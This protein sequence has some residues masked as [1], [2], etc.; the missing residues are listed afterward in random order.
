[1]ADPLNAALI[2]FFEPVMLSGTDYYPF[3]M[4]MRVGG[5]S[6]YKYGF[7]GKE[8]DNEVK[9]G[10]GTQQDYGMR[11]YD[12]RLGRFLSV[13]PLTQSFPFYTPYQFAGNTPIQAID[14]DGLEDI[15]YI[16]VWV[17]N[18]TG[19]EAVL[20]VAGW[21]EGTP[22]GKIDK[23]GNLIYD[24]PYNITAYYPAEAFGNTYFLTANYKTEEEFSNAQARDFYK[25]A[26][27]TGANVGAGIANK[28]GDLMAI[29]F[30]LSSV[31]K[32]SG[33]LI[34]LYVEQK[35]A[36]ASAKLV[37][38]EALQALM[39]ENVTKQLLNSSISAEAKLAALESGTQGAHFLSR[40][41]AQTTLA[42]QLTRATSGLTPD[43][44]VG[45]A[46]AS[47]RFLTNEL[48]LEAYEA[49]L[50]QYK[51]GDGSVTV[52]LGKVIGEGFKKKGS[53]VQQ[54]SKATAYFNNNG[55]IV[56]I[57]PDLNK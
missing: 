57:F 26:I 16:F 27:I 53:S 7:N 31:G 50:K 24:R 23:E 1:V 45:K 51:A 30:A 40:H 10:D 3:G 4:A 47:S 44:V 42:Q 14:I 9:G 34:G 41:G 52:D 36:Q 38:T 25:S 20:K 32:I 55:E 33:E 35:L 43:G 6:K 12:N 19:K 2:K 46:V 15:H 29:G 56:T 18:A 28:F 49:A 21:S 39:R 11:V 48:Q 5:E 8:N 22:T 13:D 37:N 54:T 17:K